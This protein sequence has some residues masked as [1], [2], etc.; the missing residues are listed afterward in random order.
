DVCS[1]DLAPGPASG[2]EHAAVA[3]PHAGGTA[4]RRRGRRHARPVLLPGLGL[5]GGGA[6]P[7]AV[8]GADRLA[9]DRPATVGARM[10]SHLLRPVPRPTA[11][12]GGIRPVHVSPSGA[13]GRTGG[14]WRSGPPS[15]HRGPVATHRL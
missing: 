4:R 2:G 13:R 3:L 1:S 14:S 10:G 8:A 15:P 9:N 7:V 5:P 6:A 11:G 12:L